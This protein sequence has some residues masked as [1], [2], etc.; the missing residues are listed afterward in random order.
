MVSGVLPEELNMIELCF[1]ELIGY[2]LY[3]STEELN[4]YEAGLSCHVSRMAQPVLNNSEQ[5][6]QQGKST[7][8]LPVALDYPTTKP[9]PQCTPHPADMEDYSHDFC[10][11]SGASYT[12][13]LENA[14]TQSFRSYHRRYTNDEDDY[15]FMDDDFSHDE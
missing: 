2:H 7:I 4:H 5:R 12:D 10:I 8:D 1:L 6:H 13:L 15:E 11:E 3:V 14:R 9:P